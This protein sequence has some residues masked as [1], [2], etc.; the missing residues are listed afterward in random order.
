MPTNDF[1]QLQNVIRRIHN[2][3]VRDDFRDDIDDD[4]ISTP[5]SALKY[6]C[7]IKDNDTAD[8]MLLRTMLFYTMREFSKRQQPEMYAFPVQDY[9]RQVTFKPQVVMTFLE[10]KA[11]AKQHNRRPIRRRASFRLM[12][13]RS[14]SI[15]HGDINTLSTRI[16]NNFPSSYRLQCGRLK[17]SY[18]D[19]A[20]GVELVVAPYSENNGKDFIKRVLQAASLTP[21]WDKLS[22]SR[23]ERNYSEKEY[24]TILGERTQ[25][26]QSRPLAEVYLR[27]AWLHVHGKTQSILLHSV[28]IQ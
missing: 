13:E 6:A 22:Y 7:T 10:E 15:T 20:N 3:I 23:S 1:E 5:E 24:V 14:D 9:Q 21:D 25:L 12:D 8:M 11:S 28:P 27:E 2:K 16:K 17:A 26:P 18:R 19:K 4:N